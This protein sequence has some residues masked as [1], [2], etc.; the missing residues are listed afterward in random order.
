[1]AQ[2]EVKV[3]FKV[4]GI[5]GY[6]TDLNELQDALTKTTT[7]TKKLSDSQEKAADDIE[8]TTN[9]ISNLNK[10]LKTLQ[11][12][13]DE[14]EI[15][16]DAFEKLQEEIKGVEGELENAKKG[17]QSF[18]DELSN[19]PGIVGQVSKSVKG[20]NVA[21]KA[22]LANPIILVITGIVAAVTALFKAFTSTKE[23]G[24]ALDR[25]MAGLSA[26][27]DV[28]RDVL[29]TVGE[30]LL[31]V[32]TDPKQALIDFATLIKD[33][34]VNRFE[35]L[36]ELVP[37]L[38]EA[39]GLLFEGEFTAAGK[40]ATDAV[41]K[42]TL[43]VE[44]LTDKAT[45]AFTAVGDVINEAVEEASEAARL[46]GVLQKLADEERELNVLRAEQNALLADT[47]LKVDDTTLSIEER[48]AA[49]EEAGAAETALLDDQLKLEN[50]RLK[51]L[52]ALA[53]Q[54]D[55]D[56]ATLD[57]LANQRIKIANLEEQS[58]NKQT[59]LL[60]KRKALAAEQKAIDDEEAARAKE[61]LERQTEIAEE[62]RRKQLTEK[63]LELDDLRLKY[64]EEQKLA[65]GNKDLLKKLDDQYIKD[66]AAIEEEY[67]DRRIEEEKATQEKLKAILD[68][69]SDKTYKTEE[70]RLK[71]EA[72]LRFEARQKELEELGLQ[73]EEL[74]N[75]KLQLEKG[76]E[77]ELTRIT[78][79]GEEDRAALRKQNIEKAFS[80][81]ADVFGALQALNDARTAKDEV[82][83]KKQFERNKK[84]SIAQALIST[85]LAV[86]AALTAGG[87]PIK[88][89]TGAQ[90]VEAG[91]ALATGLAQVAKIR[92][93]QFQSSDSGGGTI[94][95]INPTASFAPP[96]APGG[97]GE[98][99]EIGVRSAEEG[100]QPI[101][102]YV[103]ATDVTSAQEANAQI[104]NLSR[105]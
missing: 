45:D 35:G 10:K 5:D 73:G 78:K 102:A 17:Q 24:E 86:N 23:G 36:L 58:L 18:G 103:L 41:A 82:E 50:K 27:F 38:G 66:K 65:K 55:S 32:F 26:V 91:I 81:T 62:I 11:D 104:E 64:E 72:L 1:M 31:A 37:K 96:T 20:L 83:A 30:K 59:E 105:L 90:F 28:F 88:L 89:A 49:L 39:I 94:P 12:E 60:G 56:A 63:Q 100:A 43:G 98:D 14:T 93:T 8:D 3:L 16:T 7:D 99:L 13:L 52:E 77:D 48:K 92:A 57:E 80:L 47:K 84:Y 75:A 4:D 34:I 67:N 85:G 29:V 70:E 69:F 97:A 51:A 46:T 6:I 87:N 68:E 2:T 15:G 33:N 95:T 40:V 42:V 76:Y 22:L 74:K 19:A 21:F 25:V 101:Q 71:A 9:S 61:K 54:S 53:A 79:K 44:D